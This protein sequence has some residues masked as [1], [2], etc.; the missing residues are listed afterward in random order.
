MGIF[1]KSPQSLHANCYK[2]DNEKD[3]VLLTVP[4]SSP[5]N[6]MGLSREARYY[7]FELSQILN[8]IPVKLWNSGKGD[9]KLLQ[10]DKIEPFVINNEKLELY[11]YS[12]D[13]EYL[14]ILNEPIPFAWAG[15]NQ[16]NFQPFKFLKI[17]IKKS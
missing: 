1:T 12:Y 14:I 7:G 15:L 9:F 17:K 11:A 6:L 13:T 4:N 8:L 16:E 3:L 2:F 5:N 10:L